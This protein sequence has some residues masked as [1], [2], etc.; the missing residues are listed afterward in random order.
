MF[1]QVADRIS[2]RVKLLGAA[3]I[4]SRLGLVNFIL[5]FQKRQRGLYRAGFGAERLF[6][7][8]QRMRACKESK[9]FF[10]ESRQRGLG[11]F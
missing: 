3:R 7:F 5:Q 1:L 6:Q 11:G 9:N 10:I 2:N 4:Y 8:V